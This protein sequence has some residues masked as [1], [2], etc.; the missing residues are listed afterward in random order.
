[1]SEYETETGSVKW[2]SSEKGYG[3]ITRDNG[4]RDLFVHFSQIYGDGF[5][6]LQEGGRVEFIVVDS[7]RGPK[8]ENVVV[9]P[10]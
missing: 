4:E 1:M 3:F 6:E 10:S 2:F 5:K 9:I 7:D 8:A